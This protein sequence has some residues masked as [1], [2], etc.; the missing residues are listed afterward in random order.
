MRNLAHNY[1]ST[2]RHQPILVITTPFLNSVHTV[3]AMLLRLLVLLFTFLTLV[4]SA[5]SSA[6]ICFAI[7]LRDRSSFRGYSSSGLRWYSTGGG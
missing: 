1:S 3:W 7:V 2:I 4:V 5:L 6:N